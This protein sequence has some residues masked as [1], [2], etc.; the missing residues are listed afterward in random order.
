MLNIKFTTKLTFSEQRLV[1]CTPL[2]A[3]YLECL[4]QIVNYLCRLKNQL[5]NLQVEG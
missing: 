1:H 3:G 5:A 2:A 4:S